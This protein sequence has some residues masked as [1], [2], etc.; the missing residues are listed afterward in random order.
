MML[1]GK[2]AIRRIIR[3]IDRELSRTRIY[4]VSRNWLSR[5]EELQHLCQVRLE[6]PVR[7]SEPLILISQIQRSGGTLLSQLLDGHF[8]CHAHP[9][10]LH[11]G[12]PDKTTWPV[13]DLNNTPDGW[14]RILFEQQT[15]RAFRSGYRKFGRGADDIHDIYP[16]IFLPSLQKAIFKK[17]VSSTKVNTEREVFDCYMTSYFNAWI[18]NQSLYGPSKQF[19]TAFVARMSMRQPN[20]ERFFGVYPDGR[21]V[22]IIRDPKGWYVSARKHKREIYGNIEDAIRLWA[23]SANAIITAKENYGDR[24][25]IVGFEDLLVDTE[26]T[27]RSLASYL[28]IEFVPKLLTPTFNGFPIKADSSYSVKSHGVLR[29]PLLRHK[30]LLT[31][32]E[33]D[34]IYH[35][36]QGLYEKVLQ[37]KG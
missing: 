18:D 28:G 31:A 21:L 11:L 3:L 15:L 19:V 29:S 37:Y 32:A 9:P 5:I 34:K 12:Y 33:A 22:S 13:L 1:A 14:F 30:V 10:E 7:V 6:N 26:K 36:A 24:V 17:C 16:F 4:S 23:E 35:Q 2:K 25:Y 27:M 8:Q 20:L